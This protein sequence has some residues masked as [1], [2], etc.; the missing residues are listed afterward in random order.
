MGEGISP[1]PRGTPQIE[2]SF[3]IDS[4]GIVHVTAKDKAT[5]KEQKI[6]ITSGSGLSEDNIK[7]VINDAKK[8]ESSDKLKTEIIEEK[9]KLD[10]TI[11]NIEK[12]LK[13]NEKKI[14]PKNEI[15]I[16][17]EKL[18]SQNLEEIKNSLEKI[19]KISH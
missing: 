2:V 6:T 8:H 4:N 5:Q 15:K 18:N 14:E 12:I 3:D 7:D 10:N 13:E 17:K 16:A 9:N 11:Y 19:T 1:A